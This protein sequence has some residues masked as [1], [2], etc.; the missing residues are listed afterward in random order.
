MKTPLFPAIR[1]TEILFRPF[2][3]RK[4]ELHGRVVLTPQVF[5]SPTVSITNAHAALQFRRHAESESALLIT[6]S[7]AVGDSAATKNAHSPQ[8]RGGATVRTWKAICRAVHTTPCKIAIKLS[9][10]GML[11]EGETAPTGPSGILPDSQEQITAPMERSRMAEIANAYAKAAEAA[12]FCGADAVEI[13]GNNGSLIEQ[14]LRADTNIRADEYGGDLARRTRYACEIIHA[15]RKKVG[16]KFPIIFSFTQWIDKQPPARLAEDAYHLE[17]MLHMLCQAGVD[18]FHC[19]AHDHARPAFEGNAL[20]VA[21][22]VRML[23]HKPIITDVPESNS[24][25]EPARHHISGSA[26]THP[27]AHIIRILR[28]EEADLVSLPRDFLRFL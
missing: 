25:P 22:W 14:F 18:I 2:I 15:V 20:P 24:A 8:F 10:A 17:T 13:E 16:S 26:L 19:S 28:A 7:I 5:S 9:H 1:E 12:K 27:L 21:A 23:T 6:E 4:L 3:H 11:H